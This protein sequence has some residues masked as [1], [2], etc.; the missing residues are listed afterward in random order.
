MYLQFIDELTQ[1]VILWFLF[2]LHVSNNVIKRTVLEIR[3]DV[4]SPP[5]QLVVLSFQ[6]RACTLLKVFFFLF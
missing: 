2:V 3:E 1:L 4:L 5:G 6:T